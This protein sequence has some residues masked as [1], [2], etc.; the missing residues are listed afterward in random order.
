[1]API[2]DEVVSLLPNL[3]SNNDEDFHEERVL[4]LLFYL[5]HHLE[6][7]LLRSSSECLSAANRLD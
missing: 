5:F 7:K 4:E 6:K 1:V 3:P 2:K